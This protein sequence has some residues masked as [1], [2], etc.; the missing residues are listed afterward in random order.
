MIIKL[1]ARLI[2]ARSGMATT[3]CPDCGFGRL[4]GSACPNADCPSNK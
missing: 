4:P 3:T 2:T 1:I